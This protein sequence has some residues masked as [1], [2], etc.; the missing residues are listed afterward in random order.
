MQR[1]R[2]V[3]AAILA[4][5]LGVQ[6]LLAE[7]A[8]E[9]AKGAV[10]EKT[11]AK[12][13]ANLSAD[14]HLAFED[15]DLARQALFD[16]DP[17]SAVKLVTEAQQALGRAKNDDAIFL[18]DAGKGAAAPAEASKAAEKP[19]DAEKPA[20]AWIPVDGEFV[21]NES[22]TASRIKNAAV[23]T[24]NRHLRQGHPG[25]AHEVLKVTGA[26]ADFILVVAPLQATT[27]AV[28]HAASLLDAKDY[29][30]AGLALKEAQEGLRY[31]A[32]DLIA[33]PKEAGEPAK[34]TSGAAKPAEK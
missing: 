5:G 26:E 27:D 30:N 21:L 3:I 17:Q 16:G 31:V 10:Q 11:V 8:P 24:A 15:I 9:K 4:T 12:D 34:K 23:A 33:K 14:G 7:T 22:L 1:I 28:A 25:K 6:G 2:F 13:F 20:V 32:K 29:Y 19:N 18:K